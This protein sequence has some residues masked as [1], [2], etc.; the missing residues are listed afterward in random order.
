KFHGVAAPEAADREALPS[1][2]LARELGASPGDS[3]LVRVEKPSA[4]PLE[5]MHGKKEDTGRT[6]RFNSAAP[7]S[8]AQMRDF[9]L[10]PSQGDVSAIFVPLRLLQRELAHLRSAQRRGG[11]ETNGAAGVLLFAVHRFEWNRRRLLD[12]DQQ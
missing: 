11:V 8:A 10:K 3:L 1:A 12:A 9:S 4:I 6:I 2:A 7:L 5:S